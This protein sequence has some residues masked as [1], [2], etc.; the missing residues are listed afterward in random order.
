MYF[1]LEEKFHSK[2]EIQKAGHL[3]EL[4]ELLQIQHSLNLDKE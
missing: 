2:I 4:L 1:E 3:G